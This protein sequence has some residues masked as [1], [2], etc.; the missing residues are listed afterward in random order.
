MKTT[1]SGHLLNRGEVVRGETITRLTIDNCRTEQGPPDEFRPL[2]EDCSITQLSLKRSSLTGS[3]IRDVT[4][5]GIQADR[6]S[7]FVRAVEYERVTIKGKVT[8]LVLSSHHSDM[9]RRQA[10][11][12]AL[13]AAG[14][15][16]EWS[17]DISE[18]IG[19]VEIRGYAS[20]RVRIDPESQAVVHRADLLDGRWRPILKGSLFSVQVDLMLQAGWPDLVLVAN[21]SSPEL[22]AELRALSNLRTEG[23][24]GC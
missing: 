15:S 19:A 4:I 7:Q 20:S 24:I 12:N 8:G 18:A 10:Y 11:E 1:I 13:R 14:N 23:I 5:N 6:V 9:D 3:V 16:S 22:K 2:V 21:R 17:L